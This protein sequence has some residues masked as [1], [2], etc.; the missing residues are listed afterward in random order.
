MKVFNLVGEEPK[1]IGGE[2]YADPN[3]EAMY[4][5][6]LPVICPWRMEISIPSRLRRGYGPIIDAAIADANMNNK[7]YYAY[8]TAKN[9]FVTPDSP[10]NRPG[11]HIDGWSSKGDIN[12]I[13]AN[14]NP[15]EFAIQDFFNISLDDRQSMIDIT[16]QVDTKNIKTYPDRTLLRLNESNVH[17][18]NPTVQAGW[19]TFFKMTFSDHVLNNAGNSVNKKIKFRGRPPLRKLERNIDH[20]TN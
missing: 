11:W 20:V 2:F 9:M 6:Y 10:G 18:V 5:L 12:Y 15:T 8:I 7:R 14:M 13:W 17:R 16:E 3:M 4:Y 1:V 19:R